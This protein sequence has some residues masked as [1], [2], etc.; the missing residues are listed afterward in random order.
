MSE[1]EVTCLKNH[2]KHKIIIRAENLEKA[3]EKSGWL[4]TNP[5]RVVP[6]P[7]ATIKAVMREAI[8]LVQP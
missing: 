7:G 3:I 2:R 6:V 4:F 5:L 1:F 8:L